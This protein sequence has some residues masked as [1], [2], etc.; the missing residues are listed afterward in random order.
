MAGIL[1]RHV[2]AERLAG[3]GRRSWWCRSCSG[4]PNSSPATRGKGFRELQKDLGELN[5][6]MEESISGAEGGQGL[7]PERG[8]G[9]RVPPAQRG[10]LPGRRLRQHLRPAAHAADQRAGQLLRHR[11]G[12]AGRLAG[13]AGPGHRRHHRH[14]HQLRAELHPAAAPDGQLYNSIQAALAG[15]ERVFEIIDT[16][17][18]VR[19]RGRCPAARI[20]SRA[21]C[22]SSTSTSATSPAR[23]SSRT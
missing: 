13:A 10:G 20:G 6:V 9:G 3:A 21:R 12:R 19:G 1:D 18:E 11:A 8:G 16:P 5:G 23:R 2:R 22:A 15:A 17:A 7:P 14:V 4:S